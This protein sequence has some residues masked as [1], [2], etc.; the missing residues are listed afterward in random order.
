MSKGGAFVKVTE[1]ADDDDGKGGKKF[2]E[3]RLHGRTETK[4]VTARGDS[5]LVTCFDTGRR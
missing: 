4:V 2:Y 5:V 3:N 1:T